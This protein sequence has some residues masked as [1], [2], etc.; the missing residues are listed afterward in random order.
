MKPE[1]SKGKTNWEKLREKHK[2]APSPT[3]EETVKAREFWADADIVIPDGKTRM[4]VRFDSDIVEWF[5][6]FGAKYQTRMNAALRQFMNSQRDSA[7]TPVAQQTDNVQRSNLVNE[8]ILGADVFH[9]KSMA[10]F[11]EALNNLGMIHKQ[12]G[13]FGIAANYFEESAAIYR[14]H[15]QLDFEESGTPVVGSSYSSSNVIGFPASSRAKRIA[16]QA[17]QNDIEEIV[18]EQ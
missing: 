18:I 3:E 4:T 10:C 2:S 9:D 13:N 6:S 1:E 14:K 7:D 5:K 11:L 15:I 17:I 16:L 8:T 12:Q